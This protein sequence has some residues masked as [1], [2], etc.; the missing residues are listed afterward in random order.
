MTLLSVLSVT[1]AQADEV[2]DLIEKTLKFGQD[3]AKYGQIKVNLNFRYENVD[4]KNPVKQVANAATLRW[5]LG[6]LT[7]EFHGLQGFAEY[8]GNQD[9]VANNYN[10]LRNG[11]TQFETIADPQ[12]HELNQLWI[13]YKGLPDTELK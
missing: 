7:P 2:T 8:E 13:S 3:D 9:I 1:P 12:E 10:S 5:R 6:Y 11:K 4:T